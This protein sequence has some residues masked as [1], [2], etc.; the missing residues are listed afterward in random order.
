[1]TLQDIRK[2]LIIGSG[3]MGLRIGLQSAWSGFETIIYDINPE[4]F[5]TA[6]KVQSRII[7]H[8]TEQAP[9]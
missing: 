6:R 5:D 8:L 3:T 4:S 2:V 7:Q 1:M 9:S